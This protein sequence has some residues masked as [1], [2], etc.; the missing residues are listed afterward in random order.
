MQILIANSLR[1]INQF[2]IIK[3]N[4]S[5]AKSFIAGNFNLSKRAFCTISFPHKGAN[6]MQMAKPFSLMVE[7]KRAKPKAAFSIPNFNSLCLFV[8]NWMQHFYVFWIMAIA[9]HSS[10]ASSP[11]SV[12]IRWF[13]MHI[14]IQIQT[15]KSP[16]R[17]LGIKTG[18][19]SEH[20][21]VQC[22]TNGPDWNV[23]LHDIWK[24]SPSFGC[25]RAL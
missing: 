16:A 9:A 18:E 19:E 7:Q 4:S 22:H 17:S 11:L 21:N 6:L 8:P 2:F 25:R 23:R 13:I 20:T 24:S 10:R 15:S 1:S 3:I 14:C 5:D 12:P